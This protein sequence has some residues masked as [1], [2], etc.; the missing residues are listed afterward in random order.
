MCGSVGRPVSA[1]LGSRLLG[2]GM[3]TWERKW[4]TGHV[5][6]REDGQ[7]EWQIDTHRWMCEHMNAR[8]GVS[9]LL[10]FSLNP[11]LHTEDRQPSHP[12]GQ[13]PAPAGCPPSP[14]LLRPWTCLRNL[15]SSSF[16]SSSLMI[17]E[18]VMLTSTPSTTNR[19][20]RF[21]VFLCSLEPWQRERA[22]TQVE[23]HNG[24]AG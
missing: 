3:E 15:I 12:Q 20:V 6:E 16:F 24:E 4:V 23:I 8:E 7:K 11:P 2:S 22:Q 1:W 14:T 10:S 17:L 19:R 9:R 5:E 21:R 18:V 13:C